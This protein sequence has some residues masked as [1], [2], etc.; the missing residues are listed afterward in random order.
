[1]NSPMRRIV[2]AVVSSLLCA[3]GALA[4]Y[5]T[6]ALQGDE[7]PGTGGVYG[8]LLGS[9]SVDQ[10]GELLFWSTINNVPSDMN[11]G[12]FRTVN[13]VI[14]KLV[15]EGGTTPGIPGTT[16]SQ[17]GSPYF[18]ASGAI[19]INLRLNTGGGVT[20]DNDWGLWTDSGNGL[21]L[22]AREG[23]D[24]PNMGGA[25]FNRPG[26]GILSPSG[27]LAF[28]AELREGTGDVTDDNSGALW[29]KLVGGGVELIARE[30]DATPG[31]G[32]GEFQFINTPVINDTGVMAFSGTARDAGRKLRGVDINFDNDNG[33]WITTGE[34]LEIVARESDAIPGLPGFRYGGFFRPSLNASGEIAV[35]GDVVDDAAL[36]GQSL[37]GAYATNQ[38]GDLVNFAKT[39][40]LAPGAG[41]AAYQDFLW[42]VINDS[43]DIAYGA[44]TDAGDGAR[45]GES[46]SGLWLRSGN[47]G[48]IA[49]IVV[50]GD[51]APGTDG[52]K[53]NFANSP[54]INNMGDVVFRAD[55]LIEGDVT[56]DNASGIWAYIA[57]GDGRGVGGL[58]KIAREGDLFEVAPGDSRTIEFVD[59]QGS[60]VE[61][62]EPTSALNDSGQLAVRLGFTDGSGGIFLFQIPTPGSGAVLAMAGL[63][64]ARRKR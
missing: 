35:I 53:F 29:R 9:V 19:A 16:L 22:V 20:F 2:P 57:Q 26:D 1:M 54:V 47:D 30:G 61:S 34:G 13:G 49:P 11:T 52:A 14:E 60:G 3:S 38:S 32:G 37:S 31:I 7:A 33:L 21:E 25:Q 15:Q 27:N 4:G 23:T 62:F 56:F 36:R 28:Y 39:G 8:N 12:A 48:S 55:L 5:Q 51:T 41:G 58:M 44:Y 42:S 46:P 6:I 45:G 50:T 10:N 17:I 64:A 63:A 43:G 59:L 18:S 40:D 24:A